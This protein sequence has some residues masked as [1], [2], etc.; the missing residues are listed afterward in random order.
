MIRHG[1]LISTPHWDKTPGFDFCYLDGL[2]SRNC[3]IETAY[4]DSVGSMMA[5]GGTSLKQNGLC[6]A[7]HSGPEYPWYRTPVEIEGAG[8]PVILQARA[9]PSYIPNDGVTTTLL[10]AT[11][12][13]PNGDIASVE[14]DLTS[15]GG[16]PSQIMYDDGTNGDVT[17]GD[18]IYSFSFSGTIASV[19]FKNL[20]VT[21]TDDEVH[22]DTEAMGLYIHETGAY[23]VDNDDATF[24]P[25]TWIIWF[26]YPC[27]H[28]GMDLR[29]H[30]SLT[31]PYSTTW[32]VPGSLPAGTYDVYV[33]LPCGYNNREDEVYYTINYSGGASDIAG[34]F[35]MR[36]SG[37]VLLGT[38]SFDA[39]SGSVVLSDDDSD[40]HIDADA[41]KLVPVP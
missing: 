27:D 11:V 23:L 38:Y 4:P 14:I 16:D 1:E 9:L 33:F 35:D 18:D 40:G 24:A 15:I 32:E 10:T 13:D 25:H 41:I 20:L 31:G 37:W 12:V 2:D 6:N 21:A 5:Y 36:T 29:T 22:T 30:R 17:A 8:N 3:D 28:V 34:P 19:G 26:G 7:C 39:G